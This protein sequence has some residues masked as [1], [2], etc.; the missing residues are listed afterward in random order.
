M[1]TEEI[2]NDYIEKRVAEIATKPCGVKS[3]V[4]TGLGHRPAKLKG[5]YD[6]ASPDNMEIKMDMAENIL[7]L[8]YSYE[9]VTCISGMA[10]GIDAF[11]ADVALSIK[12]ELSNYDKE[13]RLIFKAYI[14]FKNQDAKWFGESKEFYKLVLSVAD[15]VV[16]CTQQDNYTPKSMKIRN[17][18]MVEA[19]DLI[20]AYYDNKV[21]SGSASAVNYAN[22][23]KVPIIESSLGVITFKGGG[24]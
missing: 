2:L 9:V 22:S 11:F 19:S 20:L 24:V 12:S 23:R 13:Y 14:P 5:G 4:V 15:E 16:N 18:H 3:L 6:T 7:N 8:L 1:V 21:Y 17:E 10:L